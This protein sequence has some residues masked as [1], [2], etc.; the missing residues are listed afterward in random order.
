MANI[1]ETAAF[2]AGVYQLEVTDQVA[3]GPT[4]VDNAP[5]KNLA[6][7]TLY[8]KGITDGLV[9]GTTP[10]NSINGGQISGFRNKIINGDM[11]V[12]Q[13]NGGA[14]VTPIA[15]NTYVIDQWRLVATQP[16]KLAFQQ[17]ADAPAGF[18]YSLKASVA[19]QYAPLA[20]DTFNLSQ[21][22]EGQNIVD[23]QLGTAGAV[24][25]ATSNWIKGS[26]PGVYP[27]SIIN[28]LN[29]RAYIGTINV[30]A[31]WSK[32][33]ITLVGDT[34]G[35]WATDNT[36]G[37]YWVLDLGSGANYNGTAGIW[38]T[39]TL[40]RTAGSVTF[41]NQVAGSTLNIT[42]VQLEQV[43]TGATSGTAFEH[44]SYAD[45]LRWCQRYLPYWSGAAQPLIGSAYA[46]STTVAIVTVNLP[47]PTRIPLSG[48]VTPAGTSFTF[49][50]AAAA[51]NSTAVSFYAT[52]ISTIGLSTTHSGL[53]AGQGG[54]L[55]WNIPSYMY[56]QGAQM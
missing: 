14:A 55:M 45:Q 30:T 31:V 22:I 5:H 3:G 26:V 17:V 6:N 53:I 51:S 35:T 48:I 23:F 38:Q 24:T 11:Q 54:Q 37:L 32:V 7:R 1:T 40:I 33:V 9:A 43:S 56:G 20:T 4:G 47:V 16:S 25:L 46:S 44:V 27:V 39:G 36:A 2:D 34:A 49:T 12:S 13:V 19:A 28:G 8:L 50:S 21:P 18:K 42:G 10:I 52:S 41:V 29:S 15:G